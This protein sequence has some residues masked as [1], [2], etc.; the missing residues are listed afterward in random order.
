MTFDDVLSFSPTR[1]PHAIAIR[2]KYRSSLREFARTR[3]CSSRTSGVGESVQISCGMVPDFRI[4]VRPDITDAVE[5][6][7]TH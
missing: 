1:S 4:V 2:S 3:K 5:P 7:R 6:V